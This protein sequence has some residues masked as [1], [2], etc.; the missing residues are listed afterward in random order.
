LNISYIILFK[1]QLIPP[2]NNNNIISN[3]SVEEPSIK[4][5]KNS[6]KVYSSELVVFDKHSRCILTEGEYEL[7]LQE[8]SQC[9]RMPSPKKIS[10]W[11]T[12]PEA[13]LEAIVDKTDNPFNVFSKSPTLKFRFVWT[14]E[15]NTGLVD[16][17]LPLIVKPDNSLVSN[18]ENRPQTN[19]NNNNNN[20][21]NSNGIVSVR[22]GV[23]NSTNKDLTLS[24]SMLMEQHTQLVYHFMYNNNTRQQTE[25]CYYFFCPWCRINCLAL[26][27]LLKHLKLCHARFVFTYVPSP[28]TTVQR[29]DV[30][31]NELYDG[32]Y[33]GSPHDLAAPSGFT[34]K[35]GPVRRTSVTHILVCR[36]RRQKPNLNEFL[37][38][39]ENE[40]NSQRPYITGHNR[41]D[42]NFFKYK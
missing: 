33:A 18:K 15:D 42:Y 14:K 34:L 27:S 7:A 9:N 16:R 1:I 40:L 5:F 6:T 11:E 41:Y 23:P 35:R 25:T 10:V 20:I 31:I 13:A 39:D 12:I 30:A 22:K 29:I 8:M 2:V 24:N 4:R 38:V 36:P 19:H 3:G 32:S 21:S 37:E 26:Y 17:P 28:E